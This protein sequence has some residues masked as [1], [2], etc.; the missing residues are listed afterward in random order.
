MHDIFLHDFINERTSQP[1]PKKKFYHQN[2]ITIK[3]LGCTNYLNEINDS[4]D[5]LPKIIFFLYNFDDIFF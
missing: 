1:T 4:F 2:A 3:L 5:Y